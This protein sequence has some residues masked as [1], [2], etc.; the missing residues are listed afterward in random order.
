M[1]AR[2]KFSVKRG[3]KMDILILGGA[4]MLGHKLFQ[5]LRQSHPETF[6]T[7][8]G[9]VNEGVL[10]KVEL[11]HTGNV[12]ENCDASDF[13]A[14]E[15]LLVQHKPALVINCIGNI[16]QRAA[17]KKPI[18]SIEINSLL[19]H[20]LAA[21]CETWRGRFIHFS[22]DCVF[23]GEKGNYSEEDVSDAHD[24]YGR[25][26]FLGEVLCGRALT[27]RTSIIGRELMHRESLLEWLL[28][29]NH[30]RISG[31]TRAMFSGVTTNYMARVI[32]Q[33]IDDHHNLAGLYQVTSPTISKFDLLCLL[34]DAYQ[35]DLEIVRDS[36]FFC[37]RS[38]KGDKFA[39]A[40]GLAC[41]SWPELVAEISDDDTPYEKWKSLEAAKL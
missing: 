33:M 4:G 23:S 36:E 29:Q 16:K 12:I 27:L 17:A 6:C 26:K 37:D 41:P 10:Q 30:Q 21:V 19:P 22:T 8:R 1:V 38:M 31:F 5:R 13:S 25:T 15:R 39:Q 24:L 40:T 14:V 2:R 11:F 34:K 9:S 32:E 18:P 28:Q 7:L 35:L 20:R 3:S